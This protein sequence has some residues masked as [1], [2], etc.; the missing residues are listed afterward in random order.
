MI[1]VDQLLL[2]IVNFTT[3][4]IEEM[5]PSRDSKVL[6]SLATTIQGPRFIT[7]NQSRLLLKIFKEH[8]T[9]FNELQ[10][11]LGDVISTPLWSKP[12]R[13]VDTTKKL[14]INTVADGTQLLTME[15]AFSSS[16]RK[17]L[18]ANNKNINGLIQVTPGR[19]Y[20]AD[21]TE[22]NIITIV[23]LL[24]PLDFEIEEKIQDFYKT[25]KSWTENDIRNQ[26]LLTT[27]THTNFQKQITADLGISTVI[28][29]NIINDRSNRY[30]YYTEKTRKN[31]ENLTEQIAGRENTKCWINKKEVSL[32]Q[33][34]QSI[35]EL[36]RFPLLVVFDMYDPKKCLD[37][38]KN[39]EVSLENNRIYND[40]GIYFRLDNNPIGKEFNQMIAN[41]GYNA[42]LD[43][44]TKVVGVQSGKIPKFL[45]KT[46]WKPMSV[47][48]IGAPLRHSKTA[49]YANCCDLIIAYTDNEP[50]IETRN[51]WL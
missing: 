43:S 22:K 45:L 25:I 5:M 15:F 3:P 9:K 40:V 1:T 7:E 42:Q 51:E 20:Q 48:S 41:K 6:R 24:A 32:D 38:L 35:T 30:Q 19:V 23:D 26:F 12:F 13:P 47:I 44:N 18:T 27:I 49:V 17:A 28:D 46:E 11:E 31:P 37:E 16:L 21:L 50:I 33:L 2:K 10:S 8:Q 4:T 14:Y 36:K 39:L 29:N 34:I